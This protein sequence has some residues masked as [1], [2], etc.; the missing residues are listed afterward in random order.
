M[1]VEHGRARRGRVGAGAGPGL[2]G[3]GRE[4]F[5]LLEALVA[6]TLSTLIV[7]LITGL[8]L[9]QNDFYADIVNR[10]AAQE[11]VRSLT[12][13][14]G[15]DVRPVTRGG[16]VS[17]EAD[18]FVVRRPVAVGAVCGSGLAGVI[19]YVHVPLTESE[20]EAAEPSG[21]GLQEED[22]E[23]EYH[24][25]SVPDLLVGSGLSPAS[26]CESNGADTV[27]AID[28][29]HRLQPVVPVSEGDPLLLYRNLE[30]RI[31]QSE[32]D[33]AT[34]GLFR[35]T[36]GE[37]LL[38]FATGLTASSGFRY[39]LDDGRVVSDVPPGLLGRIRVVLV[40][41]E[42]SVQISPESNRPAEFGWTAEIPLL[43]VR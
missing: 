9:A 32:L 21:Y 3:G 31:A 16:F 37:T 20:I 35:G 13:Q 18:V 39:R 34:L 28:Q 43:N 38:E 25:V 17:A 41:V 23:W 14:V 7:V 5:T 36:A 10:S 27:G 30:Y 29:F 26:S 4:G 42:A 2:A 11:A 15:R 12:D 24:D 1:T 33:P 19:A 40:D 6:L 22:G 8:F